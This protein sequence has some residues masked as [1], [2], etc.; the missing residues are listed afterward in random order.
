MNYLHYL[1]SL[2]ERTLRATAALLGGAVY[3]TSTVLL[4]AALRKTKFYQ[5]TVDR[6][7]RIVIELVGDVHGVYTDQTTSAEELLV[8]KTAGNVIE[9]AAI[10]AVGWSPIW[11]LAAASD[12]IGGTK[13][14]LSALTDDLK[15][16]KI[17]A[18]DAQFTTFDELMGALE[19]GSGVLADAIDV[20]PLQLDQ[21]QQNWQALRQQVDKLP[22][23]TQLASLFGDLQQAATVEGR[24]LLELSSIVALSLLRVGAKFGQEHVLD[25]YRAALAIIF[26]EGLP[27][28][29]LRVSAPYRDRAINHFDPQTSTYTERLIQ[30]M[31]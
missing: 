1:P 19:S 23:A 26:H 11:F 3:Q 7:L 6:L 5:S 31:E 27:S 8:R 2:P 28:Y 22:D 25:Y 15:A 14:Y 12:L 16:Q 18:T 4:P 10:A 13:T 21:L 17:I 30:S 9:I 29:L 24:S 20:L